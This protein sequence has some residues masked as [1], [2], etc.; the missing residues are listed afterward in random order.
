VETG[1]A[2]GTLIPIA[3]AL[4]VAIRVK[5][6]RSPYWSNLEHDIQFVGSGI[7]KGN[8]FVFNYDANTMLYEFAWRTD[9]LHFWLKKHYKGSMMPGEELLLNADR[10]LIAYVDSEIKKKRFAQFIEGD[11]ALKTVR[12]PTL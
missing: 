9:V 6:T 12:Y 11:F 2:K 8:L 4:R 5:P 10:A 7:V 1:M 3:R